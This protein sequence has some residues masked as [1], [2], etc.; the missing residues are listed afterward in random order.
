MPLGIASVPGEVC[1]LF[2]LPS[3]ALNPTAVHQEGREKQNVQKKENLT[4]ILPRCL[5]EA[6]ETPPD[7]ENTA[8]AFQ[9]FTPL[10]CVRR[11][12]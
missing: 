4:Y 9:S 10:T 6:S 2:I 7:S 12:H 1:A 11:I 3:V 5:A 8:A